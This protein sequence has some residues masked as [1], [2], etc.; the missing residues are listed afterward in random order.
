[1]DIKSRFDADCNQK[2]GWVLNIEYRIWRVTTTHCQSVYRDDVD[3]IRPQTRQ[4]RRRRLTVRH[5]HLEISTIDFLAVRFFEI[6][7]R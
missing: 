3:N 6:D 5:E 7:T 2:M 1:M 4:D